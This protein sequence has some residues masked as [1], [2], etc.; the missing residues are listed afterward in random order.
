MQFVMMTMI[1]AVGHAASVGMTMTADMADGG[2]GITGI[3][4]IGT[5]T[6]VGP[7]T[8]IMTIADTA[9]ASPS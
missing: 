7:A 1:G 9:T 3:T 5:G 4:A 8:E 2:R 6:I